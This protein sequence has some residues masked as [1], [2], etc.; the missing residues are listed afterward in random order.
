MLSQ[1]EILE[2]FKSCGGLLNGHFK[3]TSGLHSDT[4]LE[5]F[6]V[7]QYPQYTSLLCKE[8]VN[9][10]K[11]NRIDVVVGPVT[12]GIILSYEV[13]RILNIR[14]IFT[15]REAGSMTL[16]RGFYIKENEKVLIVED[17]ITTGGSVK[18]VIEVVKEQKGDIVGVG[19]LIDRSGGAVDFGVRKEALVT[20]SIKNYSPEE[21]PMCKK[22]IP[23]TK[24]GSKKD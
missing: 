1:N 11:D 10:F 4:Y 23:L 17:I 13:G 3:L 19:M 16:R 5:K 14:S 2:I 21:C 12:G 9:K 7:L 22:N 20:M 24:R 6:Q 18:E 8:L 15:E